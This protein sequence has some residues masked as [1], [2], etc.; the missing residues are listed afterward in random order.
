MLDM[1]RV[2]FQVA[3]QKLALV[4]VTGICWFSARS[5]TLLER[6]EAHKPFTKHFDVGDAS[7]CSPS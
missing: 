6:G 1:G 3:D 5:R 7:R 4:L 2:R